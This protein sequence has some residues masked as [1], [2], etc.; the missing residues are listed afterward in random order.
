MSFDLLSAREG[1]RPSWIAAPPLGL[2]LATTYARTG[3]FPLGPDEIV[4]L[5]TDGVLE[6]R[7]RAGTF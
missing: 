3:T 1:R 7:D 2:G 4:L 5:C 6:A